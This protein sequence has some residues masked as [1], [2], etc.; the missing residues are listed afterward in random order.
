LL[1]ID[2]ELKALWAGKKPITKDEL[3]REKTGAILGL[4]GRFA[5]ANAALGQYRGLV[6]FGLPLDYYAS[7]VDKITRIT[8]ANVGASAA[9]HLRPGQAVYL[10]VGD[11]EAKVIVRDEH[12]TDVPLMKDGAQLTL[13][14]AL[15]DLATRGDVGAG[16]L[17]MLDADANRLP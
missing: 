5:T 14:Q 12:G 1:E 7:Y 4:P 16:G 15:A 17:V 2:R 10:V 6:Y 3:E 13:R 8:I 11:A 9:K